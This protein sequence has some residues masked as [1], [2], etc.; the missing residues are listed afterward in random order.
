MSRN[1]RMPFCALSTAGEPVRTTMP[2]ETGVVQAVCGLGIMAMTGVPSG[3]VGIV[4]SGLRLGPPT[5][6]RHMRQAPTGFI[7]G[8]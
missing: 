1:S 2:S 5:S 7:L 3:L 4:P 8:W 6:T